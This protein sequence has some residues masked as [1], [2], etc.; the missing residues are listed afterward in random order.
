MNNASFVGS[1]T[2][3]SPWRG[4]TWP[5][6]IR[7]RVS[8]I[9]WYLDILVHSSINIAVVVVVAASHVAV[10]YR[11]TLALASVQCLIR[12]NLLRNG[13]S[14]TQCAKIKIHPKQASKLFF[15]RFHHL[16]LMQH[17]K[18]CITTTRPPT[19]AH[20]SAEALKKNVKK[21]NG[22]RT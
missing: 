16:Y 19:V 1:I 22:P 14:I 9:F 7:V 20:P 6:N 11:E 3:M 17:P 8:D 15:W 2:C 10:C 13:V 21:N 18:M 4:T 5:V 12:H